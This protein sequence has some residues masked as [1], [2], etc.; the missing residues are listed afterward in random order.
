M[1]GP[2]GLTDFQDIE[3]ELENWLRAMLCPLMGAKKSHVSQVILEGQDMYQTVLLA[4]MINHMNLY[5][6]APF[7]EARAL[8]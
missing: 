3:A 7:V 8:S 6:M 1:Y 5:Y 4:P 2:N